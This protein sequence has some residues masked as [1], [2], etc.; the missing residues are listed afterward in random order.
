MSK[1]WGVLYTC[2]AS[3]A[4]AVWSCPGYD[5]KT[6]LETHARHT[7]IYGHPKLAISD[8]G[9]Q[10]VA[11]AKTF[12]DWQQ[13]LD[14]TGKMGTSWK[15]TERG[16]AWRNGLSERAIGLVKSSL[17]HMEKN[18]QDLNVLQLETLLLKIS[19]I[20]NRRPIAARVFS[21]DDY[22]AIT[23]ADLLL[24]RATSLG[25]TKAN[26]EFWLQEREVGEWANKGVETLN[27][28][29]HAWWCDW[30][31][32]AFPLLLPR[33]KWSSENRN[34]KPDDIVLLKYDSKYSQAR[35]RLARVMQTF[36]DHHGVVRT[37]EI[38]VR[39][40]RGLQNEP[41][42]KC[43]TAKD[44]MRVGVQRLVVILP[45]EEQISSPGPPNV[46]MTDSGKSQSQI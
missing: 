43:R 30:I 21:E 4:V 26:A 42:K 17:K 27:A 18:I 44:L 41:I 23:P 33:R 34:L 25:E 15:F 5:T 28:I 6:F 36:P 35:Y 7:A 45:K 46:A 32:K 14:K 16:C 40:R 19:M 9:S 37:V 13:V 22:H 3:K 31:K 12:Q 29:A 1:C 10:L 24:G 8:H 39:D 38:A 11:A 2:L 20:I